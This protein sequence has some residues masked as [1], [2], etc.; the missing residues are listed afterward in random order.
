MTRNSGET[1][2][3]A[4]VLRKARSALDI[5]EQV[6]TSSL[7]VL[8]TVTIFTNVCLRYLFGMGIPWSEEMARMFFIALS[9]LAISRASQKGIHFRIKLLSGIFPGTEAGFEIFV[10][11]FQFLFLAYLSWITINL[12]LFILKMGHSLPASGIPLYFMYVPL[13]VGITLASIRSLEQFFAAVLLAK[14]GER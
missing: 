9:Y 10:A 14:R 6:T 12:N 13:S 4:G 8:I 1:A 2:E 7:L 11:L 3:S 5:A